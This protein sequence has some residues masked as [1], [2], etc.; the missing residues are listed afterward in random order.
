MMIMASPHPLVVKNLGAFS[1]NVFY[2]SSLQNLFGKVVNNG[3]HQGY[4][5]IRRD[6][7]SIFTRGCDIKHLPYDIKIITFYFL[8]AFVLLIS[9]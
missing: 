7:I 6:H 2:V 3:F 9:F 5:A 1:L 8:C 4:H